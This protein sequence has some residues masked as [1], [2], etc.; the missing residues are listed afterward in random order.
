MDIQTI[1]HGKGLQNPVS[2]IGVFDKND[3]SSATFADCEKIECIFPVAFQSKHLRVYAVHANK[4]A[5]AQVKNGFI[6]RVA[7]LFI[8]MFTDPVP[9]SCICVSEPSS[10]GATTMAEPIP[11]LPFRRP[12]IGHMHTH[13]R[14]MCMY[15][16]AASLPLSRTR[17]ATCH[18]VEHACIEVRK[19]RNII[20]RGRTGPVTV[21]TV[22][23]VIYYIKYV[24][25]LMII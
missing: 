24:I 23:L 4:R 16:H 5:L 19:A 12:D 14:C 18:V 13:C 7:F 22:L 9:V 17:H 25:H 21:A 6:L 11:A 2:R 15:T 3:L 10:S 8:H 1:H 20:M